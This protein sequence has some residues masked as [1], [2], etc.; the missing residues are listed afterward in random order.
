MKPTGYLRYLW[1]KGVRQHGVKRTFNKKGS[2][3]KRPKR[4]KQWN[5]I[6]KRSEKHIFREYQNRFND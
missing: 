3:C 6:M 5:I 4:D 2:P 1:Y